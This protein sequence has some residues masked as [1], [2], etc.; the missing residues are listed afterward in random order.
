MNVFH[1]APLDIPTATYGRCIDCSTSSQLTT[2]GTITSLE[3][4]SNMRRLQFVARVQF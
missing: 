3:P 4:N 1:H 2:A